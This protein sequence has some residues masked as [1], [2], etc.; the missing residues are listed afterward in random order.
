M[1]AQSAGDT[2]GGAARSA[3]GTSRARGGSEL[4]IQSHFVPFP[5]S[6]AA[7]SHGFQWIAAT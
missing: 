4:A 1:L 6:F 7:F 5:G 2:P 3:G